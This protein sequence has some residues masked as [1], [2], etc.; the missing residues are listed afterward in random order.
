MITAPGCLARGREERG[1]PE[2]RE[3]ENKSSL[4]IVQRCGVVRHAKTVSQA[5]GPLPE[6][7]GNSPGTWGGAADVKRRV[8]PQ[9]S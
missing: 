7:K 3:A 9:N 4:R 2:G 6:G 8:T 5:L 1:G